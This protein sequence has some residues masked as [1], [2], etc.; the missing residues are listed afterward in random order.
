MKIA[1]WVLQ[2][3]AALLYGVSGV[4]KVFM[5]DQISGQVPSFAALPRAAWTGLGIVELLCVVGL[6]LPVAVRSNSAL[7]GVAAAVLAIE[8][9]IFIWVHLQ[10]GEVGSLIMSATLGVLMA[11]LAYGRLFWKPVS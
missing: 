3:L 7:S 9:L 4:M 1:L 5:F 8:S 11:F 2:I 6:I 10:Y